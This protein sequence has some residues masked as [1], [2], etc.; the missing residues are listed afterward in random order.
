M[1]AYKNKEKRKKIV[2][3]DT[4][5]RHTAFGRLI[6]SARKSAELTLDAL[7]KK[8]GTSGPFVSM[9]E[10]GR[11]RPTGSVA[12]RLAKALNLQVDK[13]AALGSIQLSTQAQI[14]LAKKAAAARL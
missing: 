4:R 1:M 14:A 9:V 6:R 8:I 11:R 10:S 2:T 5:T 3:E 7:G 12:V 13:L